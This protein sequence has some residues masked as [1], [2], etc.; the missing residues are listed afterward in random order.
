MLDFYRFIL[1]L[2][3]LKLKKANVTF[4]H[5]ISL[6]FFSQWENARKQLPHNVRVAEMSMNDSW[7]RDSGPTVKFFFHI[8]RLLITNFVYHILLT[9]FPCLLYSLLFVMGNQVQ[10][11]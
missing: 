1:T 9:D 3:G 4:I 6:F 10:G 11:K 8:T 2:S 7:F 5:G